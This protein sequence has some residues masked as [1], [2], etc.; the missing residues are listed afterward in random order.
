MLS[1]LTKLVTPSN[2][3]EEIV[4]PVLEDGAAHVAA[5]PEGFNIGSTIVH[6]LSD[7]KIW[8][9]NW[10]LMGYDL[11]ITKRVMMMWIASFF[12]FAIFI[13]AAR[14]IA[15]NIYGKPSRFTGMVEVFINFVRIDIGR[16]SMGKLSKPYEPF[17]LTLFFFILF[18]NL[19]GLVPSLGEIANV[20][21]GLFGDS[22]GGGHGGEVPFLVKLWPG[23][24]P[25]GDIGVTASLAVFSFIVI[26]IAGFAHQGL[27]FIKNI[28]PK[29]VP[30]PINIFLW[31]IEFIL[32]F[33]KPFA[34]AIRLL[35]NMTAGHVIILV[36][37]GFI[38]QFESYWVAPL[39][40]GGSIAIYMLEI[41]VGF[42]QAYI[43]VFLTALFIA[44]VQHRH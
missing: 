10:Q 44:S 7:E 13:P 39:S 19:V 20:I 17:L 25:T 9:L 21:S 29:G 36:F 35:A 28:V 24:T 32:L 37:L 14:K 26:L 4:Q 15:K 42:L 27:A 30:F 8:D 16:D 41:F 34:L 5:E 1:F 22:H 23:I 3:S 18:G 40:V 38:F 12:L 6:H 43:F 11:S 33:F 31:L 2:T